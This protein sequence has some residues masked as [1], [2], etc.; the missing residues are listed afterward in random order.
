M[1]IKHKHLTLEQRCII[2]GLKASGLSHRSIA[3]ELGISTSTVTRELVRNSNNAGTYDPALADA[4]SQR[5]RAKSKISRCLT[6]HTRS[7]VI[8]GLSQYFSPVQISGALKK[9]GICISHETIYKFIWQNKKDGGTLFRYLR[10]RGKRYRKRCGINAGRGMIPGRIDISMRD[11]IVETKSRIGDWE[12]DTVI[13]A[14]H[15]GAIVTI[16]E[17][18]TKMSLFELVPD[19]TKESVTKAITNMLEAH[20]DKVLTITFDNGKEFA[21][22][23]IIAKTLNTKCYFATPYHS[24]ERGLNE[25][26]NGLLRQFIP[27]KTD[28]TKLRHDDIVKY[29]N[30]LNNRPRKILNFNTPAQMFLYSDT[31]AFGT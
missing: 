14:E 15:K 18:K 12:A 8:Y 7:K 1:G 13:G 10:H 5:R 2:F 4:M 21:D 20:K 24:W 16:V 30:L 29:Q 6:P 3:K 28:F 22:H 17:R 27:K 19:K 26:T 23:D 11:P 31:V 25:H 9:A